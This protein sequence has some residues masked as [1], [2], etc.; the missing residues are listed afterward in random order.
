MNKPFR[1][2]LILLFLLIY[3]QFLLIYGFSFVSVE[4]VDFPT[5]YLAS[6]LVFED[7][8]SP[9]NYAA[10]VQAAGFNVPPFLYFPPSLFIFYPLSLMPYQTAKT[11]MLIISHLSILIFIFVF[12]FKIIKLKYNQFF[13]VFAIIYVF[14][15]NPIVHTLRLGQVNLLVLVFLC[16]TWYTLQKKSIPILA[17]LPLSFATLLKTYPALF[18]LYLIAKKKY[19]IV[20]WV[21]GLLFAYSIISYIYLPQELWSD[22][23]KI[24]LPSGGYGRAAM[25][26]LSPASPGNQSINAFFSR[27]FIRNEFSESLF[28]SPVVARI[29]TYALSLM[30]IGVTTGLCYLSSKRY[31]AEKL[32]HLEFSLFLLTMFVVAPFSR[33]HH[34]VFVL[35]SIIIILYLLLY[36]K[37]NIAFFIAVGLSSLLLAW[38]LPLTHPLFTKGI[39]VFGIS[40]KLYAVIVLWIYLVIKLSQSLKQNSDILPVFT[41]TS[42]IPQDD[43]GSKQL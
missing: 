41:E 16:L 43:V 21:L 30:V 11:T 14:L 19:S 18:L 20:L 39:L 4:N 5:F 29:F 9:Y 1:N 25:D 36:S 37:D 12:F 2:V 6:K 33:V 15:F 40:I 8:Q 42:C 7:N 35:P 13:F 32:I 34:L 26:V 23:F 28:H 3:V 27:M 10:L 17:A 31:E 22:W 24:V 38:K